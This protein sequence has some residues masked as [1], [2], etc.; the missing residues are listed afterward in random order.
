MDDPSGEVLELKRRVA[1]LDRWF[2]TQDGQVR[3]LERERQNFCA[4]VNHTDVGFII[5]SDFE[6]T[7]ANGVMRE[8]RVFTRWVVWPAKGDPTRRK[9]WRA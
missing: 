8:R 9:H 6:V 2:R 7:W 1:E 5:N 4:L 3:V